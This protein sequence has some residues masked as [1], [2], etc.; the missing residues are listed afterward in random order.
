MGVS[1][2]T[3]GLYSSYHLVVDPDMKFNMANVQCHNFCI[4]FASIVAVKSASSTLFELF[5]HCHK[6]GIAVLLT[7]VTALKHARRYSS[8]RNAI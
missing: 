6:L 4:E 3:V 8:P 5:Q 7:T 2:E 1:K